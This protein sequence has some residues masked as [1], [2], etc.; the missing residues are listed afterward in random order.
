MKVLLLLNRVDLAETHAEKAK[1][2]AEALRL[3]SKQFRYEQML[4]DELATMECIRTLMREQ[5]APRS[6]WRRSIVAR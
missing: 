5:P 3:H 6:K 2:R 4:K 1:R